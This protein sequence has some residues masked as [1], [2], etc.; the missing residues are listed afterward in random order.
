[1]L[2]N[3]GRTGPRQTGMKRVL[4]LFVPVAALAALL[5][6]CGSGTADAGSEPS[7]TV[8]VSPSGPPS[9]A[10]MPSPLYAPKYP[11]PPLG[12]VTVTGTVEAGVEH[13]CLML[14]AGGTLYQLVGQ[15]PGIVEGANVTVRGRPDPDLM[16]TC[17][18]GTPLHV[19][20]VT[21]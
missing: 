17:Q 6:G 1:M 5:A 18:Q 19:I 15:D 13:G 12:E 16:T 3:Q 7:G 4:T 20:E 9:E 2:G 21:R 10:P 14:R 11:P 8:T